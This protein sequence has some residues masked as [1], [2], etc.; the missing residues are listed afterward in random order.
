MV[1]LLQLGLLLPSILTYYF[2]LQPLIGLT[3]Q[4]RHRLNE[5][6]DAGCSRRAW[7]LQ[8]WCIINNLLTHRDVVTV[9]QTC[10]N[11]I[12]YL[13]NQSQ[14]VLICLFNSSQGHRHT[15][16]CKTWAWKN[17]AWLYLTLGWRCKQKQLCL[18]TSKPK[19][20]HMH[21]LSACPNQT[22][23]NPPQISS[24]S[25][26]RYRH[27]LKCASHES[28]LWI[29]FSLSPCFDE[30]SRLPSWRPWMTQECHFH[31]F[32]WW[33]R[34]PAVTTSSRRLL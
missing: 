4:R 9:L 2:L 16:R 26:L 18:V 30:P 7:R 29:W 1:E 20:S 12:I 14:L 25:C 15:Q 6:R 32:L 10:L 19:T 24:L 22:S 17:K 3:A 13:I 21:V 23:I 31:I 27:H 34:M 11:F 5:W 28:L 33:C 8:S